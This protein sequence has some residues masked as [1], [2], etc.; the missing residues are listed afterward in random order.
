MVAFKILPSWRPAGK[1]KMN[2]KLEKR[3]TFSVNIETGGSQR[4]L[5]D[6]YKINDFVWYLQFYELSKIQ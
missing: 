2:I 5:N 3:R 1:E 4:N 6:A